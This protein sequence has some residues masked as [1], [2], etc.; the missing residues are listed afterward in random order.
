M[1]RFVRVY[2]RVL[3]K[4]LFPR[5]RHGLSEKRAFPEDLGDEVLSQCR[6]IHLEIEISRRGNIYLF[7]IRWRLRVQPLSYFLSN[8]HGR[9]PS[10]L[11]YGQEDS[12][13]QI[14]QL[15]LR[16]HIEGYLL[17]IQKFL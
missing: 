5:W 17:D 14:P 12:T 8:F 4:D 10:L 7:H 9:F 15:A 2:A 1:H 3:N 13:G 16:G 6:P 11:G